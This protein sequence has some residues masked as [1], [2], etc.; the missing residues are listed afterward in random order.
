MEIDIDLKKVKV[1]E[2]KEFD[3]LRFIKKRL[4]D[5]RN[6]LLK[7]DFKMAR[8]IYCEI[9][10]IYK[11]LSE[12]DKAKIYED[13]KELYEDRKNAERLFMK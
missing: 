12:E 5:A 2:E 9:M 7:F 13:L 6:A 3:E 10:Y 8:S 1:E 11:K 4:Y